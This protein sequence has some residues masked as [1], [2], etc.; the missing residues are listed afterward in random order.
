MPLCEFPG[1]SNLLRLG[2][3]VTMATLPRVNLRH[4]SHWSSQ[5]NRLHLPHTYPYV[6]FTGELVGGTIDRAAVCKP[7]SCLWCPFRHR[8][9]CKKRI[10]CTHWSWYITQLFR[11]SPGPLVMLL[12]FELV[13]ELFL[14]G[15]LVLANP[16]WLY[17]WRQVLPSFQDRVRNLAGAKETGHGC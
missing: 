11:H 16:F 1:S 15:F 5:W 17:T 13:D 6:L 14:E 2:E 9:N 7:K 10:R 4:L 3:E 8:T 12:H